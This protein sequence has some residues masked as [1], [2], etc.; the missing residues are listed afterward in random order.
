MDT[1]EHGV[2]VKMYLT[3][4]AHLVAGG[5]LSDQSPYYHDVFK[6]YGVL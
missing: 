3:C 5:H 1:P 6:H 4:K 2:Y